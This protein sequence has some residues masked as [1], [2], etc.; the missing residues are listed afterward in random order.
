MKLIQETLNWM[1]D[2]SCYFHISLLLKKKKI[3]SID[4]HFNFDF[5]GK[6]IELNLPIYCH[7]YKT[8]TS[9]MCD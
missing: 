6:K 4:V 8:T 1:I 2:S 5:G 9:H 3:V 7:I